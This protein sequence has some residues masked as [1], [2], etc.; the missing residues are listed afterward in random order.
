MKLHSNKTVT[1]LTSTTFV[2]YPIQAVPLNTSAG[3]LK[4]IINNGYKIIS[5]L[6]I[7]I[8]DI[9]VD[10]T[11][12]VDNGVNQEYGCQLTTLVDDVR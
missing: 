5:F 12:V 7:S 11:D 6:L 2:T 1:T 9:T 3:K 10:G 8:S 4:W